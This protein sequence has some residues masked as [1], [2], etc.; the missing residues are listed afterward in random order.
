MPIVSAH[1]LRESRHKFPP[2]LSTFEVP[3][4]KAGTI[5][6]KLSGLEAVEETK[7]YYIFG[8]MWFVVVL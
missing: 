1:K 8:Y 5:P 6:V 7:T 3:A 2:D 4:W